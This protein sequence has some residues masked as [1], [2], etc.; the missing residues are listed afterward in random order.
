[1][2]IH[3]LHGF[4]GHPRDWPSL[5]S[6]HAHRLLD[7]FPILPF[8]AWANAFNQ[9]IQTHHNIFLGYSLGGR[10]GLHAILDQPNLWKGAIFIS[11]HPGLKTAEERAIRIQADNQWA[12]RFETEPW[13]Q[14]MQAWNAQEVFKHDLPL[15]RNEAEYDRSFLSKALKIWSLGTQT[16]LRPKIASLDIPILWMVG[17]KDPKFLSLGRELSFKHPLSKLCIV[18]ETGHRLQ[19][20]QQEKFILNVT[21]FIQQ[22]EGER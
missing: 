16:D 4:L 17:E 14:L 8:A 7:D 12:A 13:D 6:L 1:M 20:A 19:F 15:Y 5:E 3:A 21:Q 18:P 22:I 10:L 11:T 9:T 2:N